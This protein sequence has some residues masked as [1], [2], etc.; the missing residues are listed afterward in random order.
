MSSV[1]SELGV[2]PI[3]D[4]V[5]LAHPIG[6]AIVSRA[7]EESM[8]LRNERECLGRQDGLETGF[9]RTDNIESRAGRGRGCCQ[10]AGS[11][12]F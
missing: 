4:L 6:K 12:L 3:S 5:T 2:A 9:H 11:C 8:E 1:V 10:G 7:T